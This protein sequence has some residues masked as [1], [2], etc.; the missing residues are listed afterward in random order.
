MIEE[1]S[2]GK[3]RRDIQHGSYTESFLNWSVHQSQV[4]DLLELRLPG[5]P[6]GLLIQ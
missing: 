3:D 5:P 4:E 2:Q 6:P 1:E